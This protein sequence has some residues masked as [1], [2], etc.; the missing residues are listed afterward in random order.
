MALLDGTVVN[1]ALPTI[2][3]EFSVGLSSL[4]WVVNAY[5]LTLS[6][7]LLLGG[8]LSDHFGRRRMF[9]LGVLWFALGSLMCGIAP[10]A[11]ILIAARAFQGIGGALLTPGSL[12]IIEAS[13][14]FDSRGSAVGAWSG[15]GGV[16]TAIGPLLGGWLVTSVSWRLI[17]FINLPVA[18]IVAAVSARHVPET[19][20][21]RVSHLPLDL[22][23]A[24]LAALGL[25]GVTYAVTEGQGGRF[26]SASVV[27][28]G[29]GGMLALAGFII[30]ERLTTHPMVPLEL[31]SKLQFS[32]A[33]LVTF[34]V[35][36][37][38]SAALFLLPL[39]LQ[40][41]AGYSALGAGVAVIPMTLIMLALSAR[42][43]RL[44][45]RI[46]PRLP[47]TLGPL[48]AGLGLLLLLRVGPAA[49]YAA[50][51]L[52]AVAVFGLGM[53]ITVAPLTSAVLAA[54]GDEHAG[55]SSA[56]NNDV[57]RVAGLLAVAVVPLAAGLST[58]S[59]HDPTAL[60]SGFHTA[61]IL[62]G[63]LCIVAGTL[64]WATIRRQFG[65]GDEA[66]GAVSCDVTSPP[67]RIGEV[68]VGVGQGA[69]R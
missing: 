53:A 56:V 18:A 63:S 17:F 1:V 69:Q 44:A 35:Y 68:G 46:G 38:L 64:A 4:Q 8:S 58:A 52:P 45:A 67:L 30:R 19:R 33:N 27:A 57:A 20:D 22:P 31:F 3:R 10:S 60:S 42:M 13:F 7:F 9:V 23:G 55:V 29:L 15:L 12:A 32:A 21:P 48:V 43:G 65:P 25:A 16:A 54:G 34:L 2:G 66:L 62:C 11:G 5:A 36:A 59:Y 6:G 24:A 51:V 28:L 50:D 37:A 41:A 40:Q 14:D 61:S 26:G 47:M 39:E 49:G